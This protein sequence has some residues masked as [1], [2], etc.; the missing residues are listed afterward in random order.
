MI[1]KYTIL[2]NNIEIL[3]YTEPTYDQTP[4]FNQPHSKVK[5]MDLLRDHLSMGVA[6]MPFWICE[7]VVI[8]VYQH[9]S[10][11]TMLQLDF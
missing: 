9:F 1:W 10:H 6:S 11:T 8:W 7:T 4:I 5:D 3:G 2:G